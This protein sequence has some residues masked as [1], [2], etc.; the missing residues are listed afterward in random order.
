[1]VQFLAVDFISGEKFESLK[2][3]TD[4]FYCDT[5]NVEHFFENPPK[6]KFILISHNSDGNITQNP[7]RFVSGSSND[8]NFNNLKIPDNLLRWFGQNV[9]VIHP[10][11]ETIPI[12][13]ENSKWFPELNKRKKIELIQ[14]QTKNFKNL[15]YVCHNT[16]TN[17]KERMEPYE[18]FSN[19]LWCTIE[20]GINGINFDKYLTNIYNHKFVLCPEGNGIDTHRT[21]ETLYCG[22]IPIEKLNKN[23]AFHDDLPICFVEEWSQITKSFLEEQYEL[24]MSKNW[25]FDKLSFKFWENK[26][27]SFL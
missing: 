21:W 7:T 22:S 26:I 12:G 14:N 10:K 3:D 19:K 23:N 17:P 2:N 25:N 27:K 13:L 6:E 4:I 9:D 8:C 24:I 18:I 16:N 11:L 15:L 1:M 20:S 5:H